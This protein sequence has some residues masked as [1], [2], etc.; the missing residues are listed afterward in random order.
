MS[1]G[2]GIIIL[3]N[4]YFHDVATAMLL[5]SGFIMWIFLK[6]YDS[7]SKHTETGEFFFK[8]YTSITKLAKFSLAWIII[9]GIPR[10]I[11]YTEFE[12]ANAAGK[13]QIPAL[14][15]KHILFFIIVGTGAHLWLK[16]NK[17]VKELKHK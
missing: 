1:Q 12:W 17:R 13:N 10:T 2:L 11:Y 5:A 8:L 9:G 7:V 15:V 16:L 3:M 14:V 4:N 6:Q